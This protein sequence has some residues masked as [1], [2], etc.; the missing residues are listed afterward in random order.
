MA[1]HAVLE[2]YS[3]ASQNVD[4]YNKMFVDASN[5]VDNGTV[6]TKSTL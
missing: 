1:V 4:S 3:V 2:R 5:D 6:F